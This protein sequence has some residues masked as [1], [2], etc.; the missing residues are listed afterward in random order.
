MFVYSRN[1]LI[2]TVE[3]C[4]KYPFNRAASLAHETT[5]DKVIPIFKKWKQTRTIAA[6]QI[7]LLRDD[8]TGELVEVAEGQICDESEEMC[9][10]NNIIVYRINMSMDYLSSKNNVTIF[11]LNFH[12]TQGLMQNFS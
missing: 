9:K 7:N 3:N 2:A 5:M 4:E 12:S 6:I 11:I 10:E 1:H 8:K